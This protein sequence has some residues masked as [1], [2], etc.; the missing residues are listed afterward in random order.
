MRIPFSINGKN[1]VLDVPP[2][3]RL[4]D[5]LR[6][7]LGLL[8]TKA[9]CYTGECGFCTVLCNN[10]VQLSCLVPAFSIRN[11]EI[12]TIEGFRKT[13][14]YSDIIKG[15]KSQGYEPCEYCSAG[16]IFLVHDLLQKNQHP[17]DS[18]ILEIFNANLC[19]CSDINTFIQA[20]TL[21][22]LNRRERSDERKK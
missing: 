19:R 18:Q 12:I 7:D 3:K 15:F 17:L 20:V 6:E 1:V 10:Q 11:R 9:G 21:A 16:R 22:A 13:K 8:E 4:V 14:E 5:V 2:Q